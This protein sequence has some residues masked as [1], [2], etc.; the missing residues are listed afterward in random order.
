[1]GTATL[2]TDHAPRPWAGSPRVKRKW[3]SASLQLPFAV[4]IHSPEGAMSRPSAAVAG[5]MGSSPTCSSA[6]NDERSAGTIAGVGSP[7]KGGNGTAKRPK[8]SAVASVMMTLPNWSK[9]LDGA[10]YGLPGASA[11]SRKVIVPNTAS[12]AVRPTSAHSVVQ[13][14]V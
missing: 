1:M 14:P 11:A 2:A 4:P 12:P 3:H 8:L 13:T 5:A 6:T 10:G 7:G 9:K